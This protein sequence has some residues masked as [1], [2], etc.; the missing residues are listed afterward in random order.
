MATSAAPPVHIPSSVVPV[1]VEIAGSIFEPQISPD[2]PLFTAL[3]LG[4]FDKPVTPNL[5]VPTVSALGGAA[6]GQFRDRNLPRLTSQPIPVRSILPATIPTQMYE[7][8]GSQPQQQRLNSIQHQTPLVD[9]IEEEG[10]SRTLFSSMIIILFVDEDMNV[11]RSQQAKKQAT[12]P[13]SLDKGKQREQR[14]NNTGAVPHRTAPQVSAT[15]SLL[16][17][18]VISTQRTL[19]LL[20]GILNTFRQFHEKKV[21]VLL[22]IHLTKVRDRLALMMLTQ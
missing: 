11:T 12:Y 15:N 14:G 19:F 13:I 8:G 20:H 4:L 3:S 2:N 16:F 9:L 10:K 5:L 17:R 6:V 1:P 22:H 21:Y 18:V 7:T